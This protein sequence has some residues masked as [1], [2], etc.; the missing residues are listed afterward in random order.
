MTYFNQRVFFVNKEIEQKKLFLS[1]YCFKGAG[2][3]LP[4][5]LAEPG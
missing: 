2:A 1:L 5:K 3:G 4:I